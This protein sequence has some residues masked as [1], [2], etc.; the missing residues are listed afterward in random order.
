MKTTATVKVRV[1]VGVTLSSVWG[2]DCT[3]AQVRTQ[4]AKE[5]EEAVW[6]A[7]AGQGRFG[8]LGVEALEMVLTSEAE[9]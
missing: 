5:A 8:V 2:D 6:K 9:R 4:G 3:V 7:L 1:V